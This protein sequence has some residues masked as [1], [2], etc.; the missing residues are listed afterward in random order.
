[1]AGELNSDSKDL[2]YVGRCD[3]IVSYL[4]SK[5]PSLCL[6]QVKSHQSLST[7]LEEK[8]DIFSIVVRSG[9]GKSRLQVERAV[10]P[11]LILC[12]AEFP[13]FNDS[14]GGVAQGV[15]FVDAM[16]QYLVDPRAYLFLTDNYYGSHRQ[17]IIDDCAKKKVP[18]ILQSELESRISEFL[19]TMR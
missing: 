9:V 4:S 3:L 19:E 10:Y 11:N 1:M 15:Y 16:R 2:L 13:E 5:V 17:K 7:Y 8:R 12:E 18:I 14:S 6:R